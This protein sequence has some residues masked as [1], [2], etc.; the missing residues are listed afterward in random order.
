MGSV[1]VKLLIVHPQMKLHGGAE[2]V[3]S[4]VVD[5]TKKCGDEVTL[6][7]AD[8]IPYKIRS[9]NKKSMWDFKEIIF[10]LR[11]EIAKHTFDI[12]NPHNFPAT[13]ATPKNQAKV[14]WMCNEVPDLWHSNGS[15]IL[16]QTV[17]GLLKGI[18][19]RI[20]RRLDPTIITG[21]D[22]N[23]DLIRERYNKEAQVIP[24]GVDGDFWKANPNNAKKTKSSTTFNIVQVAMIT[25]SKQQIEI[26]EALKGLKGLKVTFV[27]Y[28]EPNNPYTAKLKASIIDNG[29]DAT[30]L[31]HVPREALR[32]MYKV[33]DLAVFMGSGQGS[34]L[35]PLEALAAGCPVYVSSQLPYAEMVRSLKIGHVGNLIEAI[36]NPIDAHKGQEYVLNNMSWERF[37]ETY[38]NALVEACRC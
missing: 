36:E 26:V 37:C 29:V 21:S 35:G 7:T 25:P 14:A 31:G 17:F 12:I 15:S 10:T 11:K 24:Y 34:C 8:S 33:A 32:A 20:V 16:F 4:K 1:E 22:L 13:W 6:V 28:C 9:S 30:I 5:F 27:G 18:D 2:L 38:R 3:V 23:R 19:S